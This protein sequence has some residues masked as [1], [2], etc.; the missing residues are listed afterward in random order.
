MARSTLEIMLVT[1]VAQLATAPVAVFLEQR[2]EAR[3]L[4]ALGFLFFGLGLGLSCTQTIETDY[5]GMFWPQVIRGVA[6]MFCILAP[7]H[8]AMA[9]LAKVDIPDASGL[10]NLVRNLGGAIGIA[11]IDTVIYTRAPIHSTDL[12]ER[13]KASDARAAKTVG[14]PPDFF[15]TGPGDPGVLAKLI[16]KAAF[17]EAIND[18]W[19]LVAL[20]TLAALV[21]VPFALETTFGVAA[22]TL[23][24]RQPSIRSDPRTQRYAR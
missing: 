14:V 12:S 16:E 2:Y 4:T 7:T 10:F 21:C 18:A 20:A 15:A 17:V 1:G 19:A 6:S 23:P 22:Q 3:Y 8:L 5:D 24:R 13:L 11:A 9:Q